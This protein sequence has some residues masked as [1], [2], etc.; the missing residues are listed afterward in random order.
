MKFG[1]ALVQLTMRLNF[2]GYSIQKR[3]EKS[4]KLFWFVETLFLTQLSPKPTRTAA[5][6]KPPR[7]S[8][9]R[10]LRTAAVRPQRSVG[11]KGLRPDLSCVL[12]G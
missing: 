7:L 4:Q 3:V 9:P 12:L 5:F 8:E 10:F 1:T 6:G 11:Q 2:D